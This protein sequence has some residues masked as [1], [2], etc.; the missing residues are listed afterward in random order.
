[1]FSKKKSCFQADIGPIFKIF[2]IC[3]DGSSSMFGARLFE[4]VKML[5]FQNYE[6]Y[7]HNIFIVFCFFLI[8]FRCPGVS[9][10]KDS[11]FLGLVTG[12][13]INHR[14]E[15]VWFLPKTNRDFI[16]PNRSRI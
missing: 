3:L 11:W 9:K 12:S 13:K 10:D 6:T 5:E 4:N 8:C 15:E 2:E 7:K 1:M 16:I 14:N